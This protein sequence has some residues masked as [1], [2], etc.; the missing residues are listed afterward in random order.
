MTD[1][2]GAIDIASRLVTHCCRYVGTMMAAPEMIRSIKDQVIVFRSDLETIQYFIEEHTRDATSSRAGRAFDGIVAKAGSLMEE[3]L[4]ELNAGADE[5]ESRASSTAGFRQKFARLKIDDAK[6]PL[7]ERKITKLLNELNTLRS[8]ISS[9]LSTTQMSLVAD[10]NKG[11]GQI[12]QD[13]DEQKRRDMVRWLFSSDTELRN[14]HAD[15]RTL[16]E[17][18]TCVW[19]IRDEAWNQ[20][21]NAKNNFGEPGRFIWI[22]GIPGAG[23]TV[24]ASHLIEQTAAH[25]SSKGYA[26]YYCLGTRNKDETASFLGYAIQQLCR[27]HSYHVP[28]KL[29]EGYEANATLSIGDLLDCLDELSQ[30]FPRVYLIVDAVDESRPR[31]HLLEILIAIGT[32][33]RFKNIS[34]LF[35]SRSEEDIRAT[36]RRIDSHCTT[37]AIDNQTVQEDIERYVKGEMERHGYWYRWSEDREFA[38]E[39]RRR[40]S[41]QAKGMFRWASCQLDVLKRLRDPQSVRDALRSLPEDIFATYERILTD[42]EEDDR[43]VARTAL[44]LLCSCTAEIPTAK[45]LVRACL[46]NVPYCNI[47][48]YKVDT[49]N[50]ICGCLITK[51]KLRVVPHSLFHRNDSED[52]HHRMS[53]A[54]YTVKEYLFFPGTAN[55]QAKFFALSD[56]VTRTIDLTVVYNG[57]RHVGARPGDQVSQYEEYCLLQTEKAL[58]SRRMDILRHKDLQNTVLESLAPDFPHFVC[59]R[60]FMRGKGQKV[61]QVAGLIQKYLPVWRRLADWEYLPRAKHTGT[62]A[63]LLLLDWCD[64]AKEFMETTVKDLPRHEKHQ[65]WT[66]DFKL[67]EARQHET[68]LSLCVRL[69]SLDFL[70]LFVLNGATFDRES[71]IL[72]TAIHAFYD[73][74]DPYFLE[75]A[76][77]TNTVLDELLGACANP[78]PRVHN[79]RPPP[80]ESGKAGASHFAF[81]PLQLAVRVL[82]PAIVETLLKEWADANGRGTRRGVVPNAYLGSNEEA[83]KALLRL[84][85]R[86]PLEICTDRGRVPPW[87]TSR[88]LDVEKRAQAIEQLLRNHGARENTPM[89]IDLL[90]E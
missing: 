76:E 33:D 64:L 52:D 11:V 86:T 90:D 13:F 8:S 3:I 57:L 43:E 73:S 32:S 15:K 60:N 39:V 2:F 29:V 6:W 89:V 66:D 28:S 1:V 88:T 55:A 14:M 23:K 19:M 27:Q 58:T 7:K 62:L 4:K 46:Y 45:V 41:Q 54:H 42:I 51:S 44:A 48:R 30:L 38:E 81:T 74:K 72:Y 68:L 78:N 20:W 87:E 69:R 17:P 24:L 82:E 84:G 5:D 47:G 59:L 80:P 61:K 85:E 35:T 83:R 50:E 56:D 12:R 25:C 31:A 37:K 49:L 77:V 36:V 63:N 16:R 75:A 53:L 79:T 10:T 65:M 67:W 40:I 9:T 18:D 71:E 21:L 26:Y 70:R 34:L 22:H